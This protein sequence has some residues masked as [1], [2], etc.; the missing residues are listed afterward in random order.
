MHPVL[1][2]ICRAKDVPTRMDVFRRWQHELRTQVQ[3]ELDEL[4]RRR[5]DDTAK[6]SAAR[7]T[8]PVQEP[9]TT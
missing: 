1:D 7:R 5:E 4:A 6:R 3:P 8:T 2:E 9:V